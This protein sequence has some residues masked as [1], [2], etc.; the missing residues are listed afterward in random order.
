M[1]KKYPFIQEE[2]YKDRSE[3]CIVGENA[4]RL[5]TYVMG[6]LHPRHEEIIFIAWKPKNWLSELLFGTYEDRK[7][8]AIW[9]ARRR[10]SKYLESLNYPKVRK[11]T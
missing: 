5:T 7:R 6:G 1:I 9:A 10:M 2:V 3:Y 4:Y 11:L 8:K